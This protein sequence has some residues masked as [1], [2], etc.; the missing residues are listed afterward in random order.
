MRPEARRRG[1]ESGAIPVKLVF[2]LLLVAFGALV[3][4]Q[5]LGWVPADALLENF[6]PA[7]LV[8]IGVTIL[9]QPRRPDG[10]GRLWGLVWV[11]GGCWI[12][13]E[14]YGLVDVS[15]WDLFFPGVLLIVGGG[16]VWR[17]LSGDRRRGRRGV[18]EPDA[19]V[20]SFAVMAGNEIRSVSSSFR[21]AELTAFMGGV[22]LDLRQSKFEAE[23]ATIEVFAMWGGIESFVPAD[24]SVVSR[25]VPLMGAYEDKTKPAS[26]PAPKR[27]IVRGAVVMGGVEVKS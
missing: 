16:I 7:A 26:A 3:L 25:V 11:F 13:A 14:R 23:E 27:L 8:A 9:V 10:H 20:R 6:W 17:T 19:F 21:G 12:L 24:W 1:G 4:A 22:V 2:G 15:F 5:N 18:D